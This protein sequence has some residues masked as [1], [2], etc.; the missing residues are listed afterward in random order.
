MIHAGRRMRRFGTSRRRAAKRSALETLERRELL[1]V[2]TVSNTSDNT[3]PGSLRWAIQQA[4]SDM[5]PAS[6]IDFAIPGDGIQTISPG[7]P[8]L[9]PYQWQRH[10]QR[11]ALWHRRG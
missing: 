3:D 5:D 9:P 8:G 10:D 7:R 1:A 2:F 4:N 11:P 6:V